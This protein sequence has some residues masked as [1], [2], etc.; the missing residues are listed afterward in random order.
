MSREIWETD[1]IERELLDGFLARFE[2]NS[3]RSSRTRLDDMDL[4]MYFSYTFE[5]EIGDE[6]WTGQIQ[7]EV[8]EDYFRALGD[9][10]LISEYFRDERISELGI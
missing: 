2:K 8:Y 9:E 4:E 3:Y 10:A 7:V 5:R 6:R 1:E